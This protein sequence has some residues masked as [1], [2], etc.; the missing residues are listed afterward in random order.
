MEPRDLC[1]P[2]IHIYLYTLFRSSYNTLDLL[3]YALVLATPHAFTLRGL[4]IVSHTA[5]FGQP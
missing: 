1:D 3:V 5:L 2:T 4:A